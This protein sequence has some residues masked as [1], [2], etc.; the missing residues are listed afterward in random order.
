MMSDN[1]TYIPTVSYSRLLR[2]RNFSYFFFNQ[3]SV[4]VA[5]GFFGV[6][7][8]LTALGMGATPIQLGV[9]TFSITFPRGLFGILG[10]VISD[11][12]SRKFLLVICDI[13][14]FLGC[15]SLGLL[16]YTENLTL[17]SLTAI[18]SLVTLTYAISKPTSKAIVPSLV[19]SEDYL[20]LANG[21]IQSI[22]WPCFFLGAGLVA[23][24]INDS[25]NNQDAFLYCSALYIGATL[26][27][28]LVSVKSSSSELSKHRVKT[29]VIKDLKDGFF[30]L[31]SN[32]PLFIRVLTYFTY[33]ISW[34]GLIQIALPL[35]AIQTFDDTG[36]IY[37]GLM[38][39][40]GIGELL[41]ALIVGY[42]RSFRNFKLSFL[43]ELILAVS[44]FGLAF[45]MILQEASLL[46]T[47]FFTLFIGV[48]A[49]VIDIPL[50]TEIQK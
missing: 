10:G 28:L 21:L 30:E 43:G 45:G 49:T 40:C 39:A 31:S 34:R 12:A 38:V 1:S 22:L 15:S 36:S 4:S 44:A 42:I 46:L 26:S 17:V 32:R 9:V 8:T 11:R 48:S 25:S 2:N 3:A 19:K 41:S 29:G 16:A 47:G 50:V 27:A 7:V 24:V 6:L 37:S 33:T 20:Q 13:I 14:R 35:Y 23:A 5:D 18:S